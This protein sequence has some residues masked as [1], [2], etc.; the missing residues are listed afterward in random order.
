MTNSPLL[1]KILLSIGFIAALTSCDKDF[2][3]LD[4]DIIDSDIHHNDIARHY[5]KVTA[6]DAATGVV[7]SNNLPVNSLGVYNNPVYGKTIAHFVTQVSL[8]AYNPVIRT[9]SVVDSVYLYIP[10]TSTV[11]STNADGVTQYDLSAVYGTPGAPMK[12]TVQENGYFLRNSDP[13]QS[14]VS[15]Q[16]YYSDEKPLIEAQAGI[17]L[18]DFSAEQSTAFTF[19]RSQVER[20]ATVN[21]AEKTVQTLAP[22]MFLYLNK[23]FFQTK[24]L[25]SNR[26]TNENVFKEWFRGLYFKVEELGNTGEM[27]QLNFAEGKITILYREPEEGSTNPTIKKTITLNL[28]GNTINF[29]ENSY[30]PE[31]VSALAAADV[32]NGDEKLF[33]KGGEGSMAIVDIL[34]D[35]D[36][37]LLKRNDANGNRV[38]INEA[39]LTFFVDEAAMAAGINPERLYLYDLKN[40]RPIVDYLADISTGANAKLDKFVHGGILTR[41]ASGKLRYKIR[42]TNHLNNIV[43]KDSTNVK[44]GLVVTDNINLISN[45]ALRSPFTSGATEIKEI[46]TSAVMGVLGT[47]LFGSNSTVPDDRRLKL[48]IF[49]TKPN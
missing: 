27:A 41:D 46:P 12:L 24:I 31:I 42:I 18:N 1:K 6:Y 26:L 3:T 19:S 28:T 7:Q 48:E 5:G 10:Y 9:G 39:N 38:L 2:A 40:R 47:Q 4:T 25:N 45:A 22:G 13:G 15:G 35:A 49:Y 8:A 20:K 17:V 37:A 34:D 43:N 36:L 44:L 16:K 23:D 29:F 32:V 21:G 14:T 33:V 11:A 30:K